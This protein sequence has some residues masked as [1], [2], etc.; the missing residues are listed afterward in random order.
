[1]PAVA[2]RG[3]ARGRARGPR[4]ARRD[5]GEGAARLLVP[6]SRAARPRRST[7]ISRRSCWPRSTR[8]RS[9]ASAPTRSR[10]DERG[11]FAERPARRARGAVPASS[12]R[13]THATSW[14]YDFRLELD[15]VLQVVGGPEGPV[16][17][18]LP[19][20]GSRSRSRTTRSSYATSRACIGPEDST[21]KV[22]VI[23]WDQGD[24]EPQTEGDFGHALDNGHA[25]VPSSTARS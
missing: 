21:V 2:R 19:T 6:R 3:A 13:S 22:P 23:V 4:A 20:S 5:G 18:T 16:D 14:H 17:A 8:R 7:P 9:C 15:G 11:R 1:M 12:S 10:Y 25:V 24:Y